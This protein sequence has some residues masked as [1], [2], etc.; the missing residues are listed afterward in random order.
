MFRGKWRLT[1]FHLGNRTDK[2]AWRATV[3]TCIGCMCGCGSVSVAC[4]D[5]YNGDK[6]KWQM[7]VCGGDQV[8]FCL[9]WCTAV[10]TPF[11]HFKFL[12]GRWNE[13]H[14]NFPLLASLLS[15]TTDSCIN[16]DCLISTTNKTFVFEVTNLYTL[17]TDSFGKP[18]LNNSKEEC[19]TIFI[20]H[21][22][23]SLKSS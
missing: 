21:A 18:S 11:K 7:S 4:A 23:C 12:L 2:M 5:V 13:C 9:V 15:L 6:S 20:V 10:M 1:I 22:F 19:A 17:P 8:V 14:L 3:Q 16:I